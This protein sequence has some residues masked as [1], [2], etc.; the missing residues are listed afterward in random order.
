[1][2][3]RKRKR[4]QLKKPVRKIPKI[5]VCPHCSKESLRIVIRP[6]QG[7]DKAIAEASCGECGFCARFYVPNIFEPVNAYGKVIDLYDSFEGDIEKEIAS[8]KCIGELDGSRIEKE[9]EDEGAEEDEG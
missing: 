6:K 9:E 5:F 4:Q 3:R 1:M 7:E 2:G 8:N